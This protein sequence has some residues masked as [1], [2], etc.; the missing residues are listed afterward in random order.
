MVSRAPIFEFRY[1][2][3]TTS[4]DELIIQGDLSKKTFL[5]YYAKDDRILAVAGANKNKEIAAIAE[6]MRMEAL[7]KPN[8]IKEGIEPVE[9]L[10]ELQ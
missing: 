8:E 9:L 3:H 2:G 4:W 5:G 10:K 1:V 7:P 6:L